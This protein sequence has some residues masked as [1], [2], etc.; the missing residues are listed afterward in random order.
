MTAPGHAP[1]PLIGRPP[2]PRPHPPSHYS[3]TSHPYLALLCKRPS[4]VLVPHTRPTATRRGFWRGPPPHSNA[5]HGAAYPYM[6]PTRRGLWGI[7]SARRPWC[8]APSAARPTATR[9]SLAQR[10]APIA[11]R[12]AEPT[13]MGRNLRAGGA[14]T[15]RRPTT[16]THPHRNLTSRQSLQLSECGLLPL[17]H[18]RAGHSHE[19]GA[20]P[21][22]AQQSSV[23]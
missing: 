12:S 7:S 8:G 22:G 10:G 20:A 17:T 13:A 21:S 9:R 15:H 1:L 16:T 18:T 6:Y 4:S 23:A 11:T 5:S 14:M 2:T 19:R 3:V